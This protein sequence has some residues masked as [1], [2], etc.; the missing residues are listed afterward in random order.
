VAFMTR[1]RIEAHSY[2]PPP[3]PAYVVKAKET[4]LMLAV[5]TSTVWT[6]FSVHRPSHVPLVSSHGGGARRAEGDFLPVVL[7]A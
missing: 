5:S 2:A 1:W 6:I 4:L 7:E 3:S